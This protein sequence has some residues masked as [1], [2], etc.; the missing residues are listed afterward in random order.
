[1]KNLVPIQVSPTRFRL[2]VSNELRNWIQIHRAFCKKKHGLKIWATT[3]DEIVS[4]ARETKIV[5][6]FP[7]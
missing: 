6:E 3:G 5:L 2:D 7:K 1:M 4:C